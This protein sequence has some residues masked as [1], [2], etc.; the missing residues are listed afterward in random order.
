MD[1]LIVAIGLVLVLEG[2]I[3]ALFPQGMRNMVEEMA[4]L[5]D[6]T[7]RALGVVALCLG[8]LVVWIVRG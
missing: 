2:L 4:K 5:P 1:D 7:L 3:Y 6:S 8:V